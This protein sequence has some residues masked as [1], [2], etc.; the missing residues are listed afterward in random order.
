MEKCLE[1]KQRWPSLL[2]RLEKPHWGGWK[3]QEISGDFPHFRDKTMKGKKRRR[4]KAG[5][6]LEC[7]SLARWCRAPGLVLGGVSEPPAT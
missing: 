4:I 2:A 3:G 5:S 7:L 1:K 6:T